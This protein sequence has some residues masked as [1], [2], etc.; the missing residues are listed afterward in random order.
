MIPTITT[1]M[2]VVVSIPS[3]PCNFNCMTGP[4]LFNTC[5]HFGCYGPASVAHALLCRVQKQKYVSVIMEV[6]VG[7]NRISTHTN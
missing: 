3:L 2:V 4:N 1:I 5:C 6:V 7:N